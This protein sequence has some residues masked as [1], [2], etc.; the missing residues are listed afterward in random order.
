MGTLIQKIAC[1]ETPSTTAPPISGPMATPRPA[2]PPQTPMA[3]ARWAFGTAAASRVSDSGMM[4]APPTPCTARATMSMAGAV[5]RADPMEARVN[6]EMPL[7]NSRRR[8]KRSPSV[9]APSM[10][11]AKVRVYALTNH[12]SCSSVAPRSARITGSALVITRLSRVAMNIG[13]DAASRATATRPRERRVS[14]RVW[15]IEGS[16]KH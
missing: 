14:G 11:V 9:D 15:L 7:T 4:A 8:P 5:A 12:C 2:T 16:C 1:H 13:S 10:S 3:M 6:S